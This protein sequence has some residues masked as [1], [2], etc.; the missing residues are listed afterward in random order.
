MKL[1][2]FTDYSP[3]IASFAHEA[4]FGSLQLSAW[5]QSALN[6]DTITDARVAEIRADL[7]DKG[8]ELSALGY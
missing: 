4:G 1:G 2:F 3:A 6:A 8:L 5:P 7:D